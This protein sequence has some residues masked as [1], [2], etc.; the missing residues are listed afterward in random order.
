MNYTK[1]IDLERIVETNVTEVI[2]RTGQ[3]KSFLITKISEELKEKGT[4]YMIFAY[5][6]DLHLKNKFDNPV[7]DKIS[8]ITDSISCTELLDKIKI[9]VSETLEKNETEKL[10]VL[11]DGVIPYKENSKLSYES[12]QNLFKNEILKMAVENKKL[13]F[14]ITRQLNNKDKKENLYFNYLNDFSDLTK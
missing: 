7:F 4:K 3:G 8:K 9:D 14:I 1:E 12:I 13:N 10:F 5:D 6:F 11:L 2:G